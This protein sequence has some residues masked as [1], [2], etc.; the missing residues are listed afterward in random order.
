MDI[1]NRGVPQNSS[2]HERRERT[3]NPLVPG[4]SPGG[5]T[6]SSGYDCIGV[7]AIETIASGHYAYRVISNLFLGLGGQRLDVSSPVSPPDVQH[8]EDEQR[9]SHDDAASRVTALDRLNDE[10]LHAPHRNPPQ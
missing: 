8:A 4:S 2:N 10:Y 9:K 1:K 6:S 3:H 5:P 7:A